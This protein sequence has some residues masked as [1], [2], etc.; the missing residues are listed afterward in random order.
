MSFTL[1]IPHMS[2]KLDQDIL[3][4]TTV[5]TGFTFHTLLTLPLKVFQDLFWVNS[6][7]NLWNPFG[8]KRQ[9]SES[10]IGKVKCVCYFCCPYKLTE[11]AA[12]GIITVS[13]CELQWQYIFS[14]ILK[15]TGACAQK[16]PWIIFG[17]DSLAL[18]KVGC[19]LMN[20]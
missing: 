19:Y 7:I 15:R 12:A 6:V 3:A 2:K 17:R 5:A 1:S 18:F 20:A 8:I 9:Q 14:H 16:R 10:Q 11:T 4:G 13:L